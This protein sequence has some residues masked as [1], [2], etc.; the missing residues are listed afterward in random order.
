MAITNTDTIARPG[1]SERTILEKIIARVD[2]TA[3]IPSHATAREL[4]A[5]LI[6]VIS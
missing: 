2:N 1:D 6:S 5:L 4:L 3:P